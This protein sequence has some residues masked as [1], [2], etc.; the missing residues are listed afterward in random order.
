[1]MRLRDFLNSLA[2]W[3]KRSPAAV[4]QAE[5]VDGDVWIW[6]GEPEIEKPNFFEFDVDVFTHDPVEGC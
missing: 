3:I 6:R 2:V 1:M 4:G 5:S